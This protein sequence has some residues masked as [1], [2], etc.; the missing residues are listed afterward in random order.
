M[1]AVVGGPAGLEQLLHRVRTT[2]AGSGLH[3]STGGAL[4]TAGS[5]VERAWQQADARMY[6]V[7]RQARSSAGER[8]AGPR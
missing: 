5:P 8:G 4:R 1:A 6:E 2:L 7:K 3:V